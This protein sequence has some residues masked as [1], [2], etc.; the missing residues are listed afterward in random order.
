MAKTTSGKPVKNRQVTG[1]RGVYLVAAEL[2]KRGYIVAPTSRGAMGADLLVT[3]LDCSRSFAV[4]VKANTSR[5]SFFLIGKKA[6]E[7][8][9]QSIWVMIDIRD[10]RKEGES[11]RVDH[12][13]LSGKQLKKQGWHDGNFP[14]IML[15]KMQ[16]FRED[17]SVFD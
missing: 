5:S 12:Y 16:E 14:N 3:S 10:S 6:A 15:N 7:C 4:Q 17:W 8:S 9:D 11:D 2:S 13:I 1:M